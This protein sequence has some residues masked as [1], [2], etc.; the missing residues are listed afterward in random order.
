[1][2][3][4]SV[5]AV[6]EDQEWLLHVSATGE[7]LTIDES[8]KI[9]I[10]KKHELC[11]IETD[12]STYK[13]GD[14]VRFLVV[15][16]DD[17]FHAVNKK[18]DVVALEDPN[19]NRIAQ[20]LDVTPNH[21]FADFTFHL[22]KDLNIG[23]Y[24]INIPGRC[25]A[26]FDVNEYVSKRFEL[27]L[28]LPKK[29]TLADKS[30][31]LDACG[32]YTYGKPVQGTIEAEVCL[33][34]TWYS[35]SR[36]SRSLIFIPERE[37]VPCFKV[38][39]KT[40]SKGCLSK[41]IDLQ[42]FKLSDED[43]YSQL[44]ISASLTEDG[45]DHKEK[46]YADLY[47]SREPNVQFVGGGNVYHKGS[48][49]KCT[50]SFLIDY[51]INELGFKM[52]IVKVTD[53]EN[54]PITNADVKIV[55]RYIRGE[56]A[57]S[58]KEKT[59][60]NGLAHV[61]LSTDTWE[62]LIMLLAI[63][64]YDDLDPFL[65]GWGE[66]NM[67]TLVPLDS[68]SNSFVDVQS[69]SDKL[70]CDLDQSVKV[71]YR[72]N[73]D[74]LDSKADHISFFCLIAPLAKSSPAIS[75]VVT[76]APSPLK[77]VPALK[78]LPSNATFFPLVHDA[79]HGPCLSTGATHALVFV[80][81][82]KSEFSAYVSGLWLS[83]KGSVMAKLY[84]S[85]EC[86]VVVRDSCGVTVAAMHK[87]RKKNLSSAGAEY[88]CFL[89][90]VPAFDFYTVTY[91][92]GIYSQTEHRRPL[93]DQ[94]SGQ[95]IQGS[96][97][98]KFHTDLSSDMGIIVYSIL[99]NGET[100]TDYA[101]YNIEPCIKNKV[102]LKYSEEQVHPGGQVTLDVSAEPGS[103]CSVRAVDRG[104]L[105]QYPS[106]GTLASRITSYVKQ[107]FTFSGLLVDPDEYKCPA[108]LIL[109]RALH[110]DPAILFQAAN[111]QVISNAQ[112]KQPPKCFDMDVSAR[113]TTLKRKPGKGKEEEIRK[114]IIRS[115]FPD[116]WINKIV[117][118][119][120]D[121]H[122]VLDLTTPHSITKW[123]TGAFCLGA[124]GIGEITNVGLTS[125]KEYFIE[126]IVPPS[127]VQGEKFKIQAMVFSYQ[128]KCIL[129]VVAAMSEDLKIVENQVQAGCIYENKIVV[130][131]GSLLIEGDCKED[132]AQISQDRRD[133]S[134][135]K[136]IQVKPRGYEAEITETHILYP[137]GDFLGSIIVNIEELIRL[138]D[139]CGEQAMSKFA[140]YVYA[141]NYLKSINELTP[142][143]KEKLTEGLSKGYQKVLTF[144]Q[145]NGTYGFFENFGS[146]FWITA[147]ALKLMSGAQ[148]FMYIDEK[149][150]EDM[151]EWIES[152]Q[153][154]S[155]CFST[156][157]RYFCN[158]VDA[159]DDVAR[160]SFGLIALLEHHDEHK[161]TMVEKA[162]SCIRNQKDDV[163]SPFTLATLA[164][165]FTLAGDNENRALML[166][167]LEEVAVKE[168]GFKFWKGLYYFDGDL[169]TAAY[170]L[171]ALV[172]KQTLKPE[173]ID[174]CADIVRWIANKQNSQ[175]GFQSSQD[176]ALAFQALASYAKAT[177][178]KKGDA[179]VIIEGPKF[180]KEVH[181]SKSESL[182]LHTV[183]LPHIPEVYTASLKGNGF[184][185]V[186][187]HI[188]Y[189]SI[190]DPKEIHFAV[191][192]STNPSTCSKEAQTHF[193]VQI[194]PADRGWFTNLNNTNASR[195]TCIHIHT[196]SS[197]Q[198]LQEA[199]D[200]EGQSQQT[201]QG[202]ATPGLSPRP[203]PH[204]DS[205]Q[206]TQIDIV[207][208]N[209][210]SPPIIEYKRDLEE[211]THQMSQTTTMP[212]PATQTPQA[213]QHP[214]PHSESEPP[215]RATARTQPRR[216][217]SQRR[218]LYVGK[219]SNT[220]MAMIKVELLS[221][222]VPDKKS[223][224]QFW[225][226]LKM[227]ETGYS[228]EVTI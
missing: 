206:R 93:T 58:V 196:P 113:T 216:H 40:D 28:K 1:M 75:H 97:S 2:S 164:Y 64:P 10:K 199:H 152:Q 189:H 18:Y 132:P 94:L 111:L 184:A 222:F 71:N 171:L 147:L 158:T 155:G 43:R 149:Q 5:P 89:P 60:E 99:Q 90:H 14:T 61:S 224:E 73:K 29:V 131:S 141:L 114:R 87:G 80:K 16:V 157:N 70:P 200:T 3:E 15:S 151:F 101:T 106:W 68:K 98:L 57:T 187:S 116:T 91:R 38:N 17:Q 72:I 192:V 182:V 181:L 4:P 37:P 6:K 213:Q 218:Q 96:F 207:D 226:I 183:D 33:E 146:D 120:Q 119:G 193:E 205:Q 121:G 214:H 86:S 27:H 204:Q 95:Y 174:Q 67:L 148:E 127:V 32:S 153:Q 160:T 45:T 129:M 25:E 112:I 59:D 23:G 173:D 39:A 228:M 134:I 169:Q 50:I 215:T 115:F 42:Q 209:I 82:G 31:I 139:G 168:H 126:L 137:S 223:I 8:K 162:L 177:S 163:T 125:F 180:H 197:V 122:T 107:R 78:Y 19:R 185:Y 145:T 176:T 128:P 49:F 201:T 24:R 135:E 123:E 190:P 198:G 53:S 79:T 9:A 21:G 34:T 133:D 150:F 154:P 77:Y 102:Q 130:N 51:H 110:L 105:L 212:V 13:P 12:K 188:H 48:Q 44:T 47:L 109:D 11:V 221:G 117:T 35:H 36:L 52:R 20:W 203:M 172:S 159:N 100:L 84:K 81:L 108:N 65:Y 225:N 194:E 142:E 103:L 83:W 26:S 165:A 186:Q 76:G 74:Q 118:V 156:T 138:P 62:G 88:A 166:K 140:R 217:I 210:V 202:Q 195:G 7:H 136:N 143:L 179:T 124:S 161:K 66:H 22:G 211:D 178:D 85:E 191:N 41:E 30:F 63:Y 167:R 56:N 175:G 104:Y 144:K 92:N 220:N 69:V 46:E 55:I 54:K 170:V 208:E 227:L 219:R